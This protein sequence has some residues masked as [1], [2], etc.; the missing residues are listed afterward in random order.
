MWQQAC[1]KC[2]AESE[3]KR[4][5]EITF[6]ATKKLLSGKSTIWIRMLN[7]EGN[8]TAM[9]PMAMAEQAREAQYQEVSA[10]RMWG[11]PNHAESLA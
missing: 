2:I 10:R 4:T 11:Q 1:S 8:M 9:D 3:K 6:K 5:P 7:Q